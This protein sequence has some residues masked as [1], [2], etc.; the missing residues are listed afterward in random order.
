ML[1]NILPGESFARLG[2]RLFPHQL[3][4]HSLGFWH[5]A[6]ADQAVIL[7]QFM[8]LRVPASSG[9]GPRSSERQG[10]TYP[11]PAWA[12]DSGNHQQAKVASWTFVHLTV[13]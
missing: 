9:A 12:H 10:L 3:D 1:K 5:A 6:R 13:I 11:N 7:P 4:E 2:C 8:H